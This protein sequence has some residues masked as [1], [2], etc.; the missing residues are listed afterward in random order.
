MERQII[1]Y[2]IYKTPTDKIIGLGGIGLSEDAY[3]NLKDVKTT[4]F[5]ITITNDSVEYN[6]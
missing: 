2:C 6:F 1:N 5:V 3:D 4:E